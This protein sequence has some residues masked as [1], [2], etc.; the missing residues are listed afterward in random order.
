MEL[1]NAVMLL[2]IDTD[3]SF[4]PACS[5]AMLPFERLNGIFVALKSK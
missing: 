5:S 4:V 2:G 3:L 1:S